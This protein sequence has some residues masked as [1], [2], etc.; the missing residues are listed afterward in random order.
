[1]SVRHA[2]PADLDAIIALEQA[3]ASGAHWAVEQYRT[4]LS[5]DSRIALIVEE[6]SHVI[7]FLIARGV[8]KEWELE[9]IVVAGTAQRGGIGTQLMDEFLRRVRERNASSISLEVRESNLAALRLYQSCDFGECGRRKNYYTNPR[10]DALV[11]KK[12]L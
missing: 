8:E 10:E 4:A 7:G 11:Y 1:L 3:A 5:E 9:N 12:M 6:N 2:T